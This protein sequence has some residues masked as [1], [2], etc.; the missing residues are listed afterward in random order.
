[1]G[2]ISFFRELAQKQSA[3][4]GTRGSKSP[5][6]SRIQTVDVFKSEPPLKKIAQEAIENLEVPWQCGQ[7]Q[8]SEAK[9]FSKQC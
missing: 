5:T 3:K 7:Q 9:R 8:K 1:M 6:S 2:I 4:G